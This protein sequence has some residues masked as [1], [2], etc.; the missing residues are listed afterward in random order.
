VAGSTGRH[1]AESFGEDEDTEGGSEST[2]M[3]AE[4]INEA[5]L[6]NFL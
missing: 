3:F 5:I 6:S 2:Q 1:A 4:G